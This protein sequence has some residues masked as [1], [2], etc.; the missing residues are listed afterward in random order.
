MMTAVCQT[1]KQAAAGTAGYRPNTATITNVLGTGGYTIANAYDTGTST[2]VDTSTS[3]GLIEEGLLATSGIK[4]GTIVFSGFSGSTSK[5]GTL[6]VYANSVTEDSVSSNGLNNAIST[7]DIRYSTNGGTSWS[8]PFAAGSGTIE[9]SG[10][11]SPASFSV[12]PSSLQVKVTLKSQ[13]FT[14]TVLAR[15]QAN[16][17]VNISDVVFVG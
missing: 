7:V 1:Y 2:T 8:L 6:T 12:V 9:F 11:Q 17:W 15:A 13:I 14:G 10:A 5:T 4:T 3:T 16:C